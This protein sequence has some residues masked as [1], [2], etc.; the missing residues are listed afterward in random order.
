MNRR[1]LFRF[2]ASAPAAALVAPA[3][4]KEVIDFS[5][6]RPQGAAIFSMGGRQAGKSAAMAYLYGMNK[7]GA[8]NFGGA[9]SGRWTSPEEAYS[10]WQRR[11]GKQLTHFWEPCNLDQAASRL[12]R[13]E[14]KTLK[15]IDMDLAEIEKK[16]MQYA[17]DD[18]PFTLKG[19]PGRKFRAIMDE[20]Y[21][22]DEPEHIE[23][24]A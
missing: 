19:L 23:G 13:T 5:L 4:A 10:I 11:Y 9:Y 22:V 24:L 6:L 7:Y 16:V 17:Q 3:A 12:F 20:I 2:L 8:R 18:K 15:A 1:G 14:E 21:E